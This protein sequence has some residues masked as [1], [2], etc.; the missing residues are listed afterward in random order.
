[1]P[2]LEKCVLGKP[3]YGTIQ[4]WHA[5][6]KQEIDRNIKVAEKR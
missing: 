6:S 5:S 4:H 3:E 1:M 2:I